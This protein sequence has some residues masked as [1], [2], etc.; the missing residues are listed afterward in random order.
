VQGAGN[1]K[2]G[3][4]CCRSVHKKEIDSL[5]L[6]QR[7]L[8]KVGIQRQG[9]TRE[10]GRARE[11]QEPRQPREKGAAAVERPAKRRQEQVPY[12]TP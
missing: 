4:W 7:E 11:L 2:E 12:L 8:K 3:G 10:G 1:E 6:V 9:E 5:N